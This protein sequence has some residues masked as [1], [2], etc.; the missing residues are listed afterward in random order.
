MS[1]FGWKPAGAASAELGLV[2][3]SIRAMSIGGG[4]GRPWTPG[5]AQAGNTSP[6]SHASGVIRPMC[7]VFACAAHGLDRRLRQVKV[8]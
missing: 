1:G 3:R 5:A 4:C 2:A 8:T 7:E 6:I